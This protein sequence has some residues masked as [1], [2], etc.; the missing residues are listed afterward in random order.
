M[1]IFAPP[2]SFDD[3]GEYFSDWTRSSQ[4]VAGIMVFVSLAALT[5]TLCRALTMLLSEPLGFGPPP[6]LHLMLLI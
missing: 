6:S 1:L 2:T 4:T 3:W 5:L